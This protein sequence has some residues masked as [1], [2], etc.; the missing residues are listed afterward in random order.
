M[1]QRITEMDLEIQNADYYYMDGQN[2]PTTPDDTETHNKPQATDRRTLLLCIIKAM[3]LIFIALCVGV[4]SVV[5]KVT[6]VSIT[7]RTVTINFTQ[8]SDGLASPKSES[9]LYIQLTLL[10][11]IPE[12]VS[13]IRCLVWGVIGKTSET[14]PWPSKL[15]VLKVSH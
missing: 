12:V 7:S 15:A 14:Y 11:V 13:F 9:V 5:S 2:H 8:S 6:L 3:A 4:G 1:A 10:L